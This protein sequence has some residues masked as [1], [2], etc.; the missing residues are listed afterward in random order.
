MTEGRRTAILIAASEFPEEPLPQTLRCPKNDVAGL[1]EALTFIN[2]PSHSTLRAINRVFKEA[3]RDDQIL[4]YYSGHGKQDGAGFTKHI[5]QGIMQ[6]EA[7]H[8][9]DGMIS[10]DDLYEYALRLTPATS[11]SVF[12]L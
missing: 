5:L 12:V 6:G 1:A 7:D 10:L 2:E 3:G 8:D 4:I 11:I 9:D